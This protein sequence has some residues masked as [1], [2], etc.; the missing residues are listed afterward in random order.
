MDFNNLRR[1]SFD[2]FSLIIVNL[3]YWGWREYNKK[4]DDI[5]Y[6]FTPN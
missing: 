5:D 6:H 4:A 1:L 2:C 3:V